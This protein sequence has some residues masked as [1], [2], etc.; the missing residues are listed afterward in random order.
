MDSPKWIAQN[1]KKGSVTQNGMGP[2]VSEKRTHRLK[3]WVA[4]TVAGRSK[5]M[6]MICKQKAQLNTKIEPLFPTSKPVYITSG[7]CSLASAPFKLLF[8]WLLASLLPS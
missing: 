2:F 7:A 6:P 3:I 5:W 4:E 8:S 1:P